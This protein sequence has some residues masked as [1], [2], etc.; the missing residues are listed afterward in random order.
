M[1]KEALKGIKSHIHP[2]K[3]RFP[4]A[5]L[6]GSQEVSWENRSCPIAPASCE[7]WNINQS[8]LWKQTLYTGY[9]NKVT[10][11]FYSTQQKWRR[12]RMSLKTTRW[13]WKRGF[14][15]CDLLSSSKALGSV[16][17]YGNV[18]QLLHIKSNK[19]AESH[20]SMHCVFLQH[21]R[22]MPSIF[23]VS[24]GY[25]VPRYLTVNKR[26]PALL[27]KNAMRV[28]PLNAGHGGDSLGQYRFNVILYSGE[29]WPI[30]KWGKLVLHVPLL[31]G[32]T[33]LHRLWHCK[34]FSLQLRSNGDNVVVGD[35]VILT[36]VNA[37]QQVILHLSPLVA[38]VIM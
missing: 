13:S 21:H 35:K 14:V 23:L 12:S 34:A 24:Q 19:W 29:S 30:W 16:I 5:V 4:K 7:F 11:L 36:P 27:E 22:M 26:L 2:Q 17:Q 6:G 28:G 10:I 37:G 9:W 18:V 38:I 25:I 31:Q 20:N 1:N 3:V 8:G 32:Q 15:K 33:A